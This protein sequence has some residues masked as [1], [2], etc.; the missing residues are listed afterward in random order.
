[1][2]PLE[3]ETA[4]EGNLGEAPPLLVYGLGR[5]GLPVVARATRAGQ[6]VEFFDAR[7]TGPDIN[8]AEVLGAKRISSVR[9]RLQSAPLPK[10]VVAAP[11]VPIDHPDL[12]SLRGVGAEV[13]GEVEWVWRTTPGQYVGVTGTAGKGT[14]TAWL[15]ATLKH[16]GFPA[17][18]GGNIDPALTQ[19][20]EPG[21]Y[22]VV[23][24]S[25]FQL[26]RCSSFSPDVAVVLNLGEDHIDRHGSVAAYHRAKKTLVLNLQAGQ[27]LVI[28]TDDSLLAR[29][30]AEAEERGVN[31]YRYSLT[32]PADAWVDT[33]GTLRVNGESLLHEEELPVRGK[34][35]VSNAL[36]VALAAVG[37]GLQLEEIRSGLPTFSGLAGRYSSAGTIGRVQ[38]IED[39]IATRPLAVAAALTS[40]P[41]PLVWLA[42]G[43][44]K[45][46][47]LQDLKPLVKE[48]V[49]LLLAFGESAEAF[50][51]EFSD[52][53]RV[54]LCT[55]PTGEET[56]Q[57]VVARSLAYLQEAHGGAGN[58]LLAPLAT[59]FDQFENYQARGLAFRDAVTAAQRTNVRSD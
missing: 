27:T 21:R 10:T 48:H 50:A 1:M 36:A 29:W 17:V 39:S 38:F 46:S 43:R 12:Q 14:V 18:A 25:S 26:E 55:R 16:V 33:T 58:V 4:R 31:V 53:A 7:A 9:E 51:A 49:D 34:H 23:E 2:K 56:M 20:A 57:A 13:I 11:G 24:L 47:D 5:S 30:G 52:Y 19:V 44:A 54:E 35:N 40:T 6:K 3:P 15:A 22:H 28:N 41:R 8:E 42:G 37:L 59:S 45:G 32:R